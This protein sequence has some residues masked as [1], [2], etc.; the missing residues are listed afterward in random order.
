MACKN[1][2]GLCP[3]FIISTGVAFS[4]GNLVISIPAGSYAN[5]EKY[6]IVVAQAI[7]GN[8]TINAPVMVRIGTGAALYPV[9]KRNCTQ[10][11]AA[12][13]RTRTKYSGQV[14]TTATGGSFRLLGQP[15][16]AP[17]NTLAVLDGGDEA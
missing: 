3:R 6:C 13:L 12:S 11:T 17:S 2:C 9:T 7:P 5:G 1:I 15:C 16:C 10:L 14:V 8:T 4:G